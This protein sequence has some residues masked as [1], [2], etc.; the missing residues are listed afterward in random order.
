[1]PPPPSSLPPP[2]SSTLLS[3]SSPISSKFASPSKFKLKSNELI[4]DL[5]GRIE[6][7]MSSFSNSCDEI[8][9]KIN[10]MI[11][12]I[13]REEDEGREFREIENEMEGRRRRF[14]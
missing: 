6:E 13:G 8:T 11:R 3:P 7:E 10:E 1:M 4:E 12:K 14:D 2:P 9:R 5:K